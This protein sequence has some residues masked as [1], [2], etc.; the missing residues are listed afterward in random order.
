[1]PL[2]THACARIY[3]TLYISLY[4]NISLYI[5]ISI[6]YDVVNKC[7]VLRFL[8]VIMVL[9]YKNNEDI[10]ANVYKFKTLG[11]TV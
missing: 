7:H 3:C 10:C 1:M 11:K 2:T 6:F 5:I 9:I 4:H 8:S